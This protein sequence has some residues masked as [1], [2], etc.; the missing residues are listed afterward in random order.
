MTAMCRRPIAPIQWGL[1][2]GLAAGL[3][4][5]GTMLFGAGSAGATPRTARQSPSPSVT[6]AVP[7]APPTTAEA[8][9]RGSIDDPAART[10]RL[11]I[12]GLVGMGVVIAC[13][14]A[15]FWV[16]T[17]PPLRDPITVVPLTEVTG[18]VARVDVPVNRSTATPV[19]ASVLLEAERSRVSIEQWGETYSPLPSQV[20][21]DS[22]GPITGVVQ[23]ER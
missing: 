18:G 6:A 14:T 7:T 4:A 9:Q 16:R 21:A 1:R 2:L 22:A 8:Q 23:E 15:Y 12:W 11:V 13:G 20:S 5:S 3:L 10:M 17:R 19:D